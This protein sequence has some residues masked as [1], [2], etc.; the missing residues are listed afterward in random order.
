ENSEWLVGGFG[1]TG[2][3]SAGQIGAEADLVICIGTRLTDF[4]TGSNSAFQCP[5][6]KVIG[7]NVCSHDAYKIGALPIVAD[8]REVLVR[9]MEACQGLHSD[10]AWGDS[11]RKRCNEWHRRL[12]EDVLIS[13]HGGTMSQG[14]L[15]RIINDEAQ[16]GDTI[17]AAAGTPPADLHKIWDATGGNTCH[18]EFGFS[19]MGYEIPAA[20]GIRLAQREGEIY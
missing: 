8:A 14:Q 11:I 19:C 7:I 5:E 2:T 4:V 10:S 12:R 3:P 18:L 13:S 17:V 16:P 6:V 1:V 9:L 20:I 15:I